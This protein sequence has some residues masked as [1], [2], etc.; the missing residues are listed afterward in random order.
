[1]RTRLIGLDVAKGI[2]ILLVVIGHIVARGNV[3]GAEWYS[4]LKHLIYLFHMPLFMVLSGLA[5]G[6]SW[7]PKANMVQVARFIKK[8]VM[9]FL[10]LYFLFG[11]LIVGGKLIA[12][13]FIHV[14]NQP[15]NFLEGI[16]TLVLYPM[17]S[18]S[19]FLWYIQLLSL[20]FMVVP[21]LLQM[22]Q[23]WSAWGI[24]LIGLVLNAFTWSN[25]F[26]FVGFVEYLPFF[27]VGILLGQHWIKLQSRVLAPQAW[28][29]WVFPFACVLVFSL[30]IFPLPKWLVGTLS[31]PFVLCTSQS[32]AGRAEKWLSMLGK[33][34]LVIYLLNTI[35]IGLTKAILLPLIPW[36][37]HYF[38]IFFILLGAAGLY[39]PILTKRLLNRV[40]PSLVVYI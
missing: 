9:L 6:L 28:I 20:Y 15:T 40:A 36:R 14:D 16:T 34:T 26:N 5:L 33:Q 25:L 2:A 22:S 1:M 7:E 39:L 35:F 12:A 29:F 21:W 3:P 19:S 8:R 38:L 37:E 13:R 23:R 32:V 30:F 11:L 24:L 18:A 31:V 27:A 10:I 4:D 17:Q